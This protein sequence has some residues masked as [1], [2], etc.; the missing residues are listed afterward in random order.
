MPFNL[1][2]GAPT[3]SACYGRSRMLTLE[4]KP[5]KP[6]RPTL[7][8]GSIVPVR[9]SAEDPGRVEAAARPKK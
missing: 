1:K 3:G 5:K 4:P 7:A 8:R 2:R 6:R 9:F